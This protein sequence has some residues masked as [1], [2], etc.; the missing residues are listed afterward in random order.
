[1]LAPKG[2]N[3]LL[4]LRRLSDGFEHENHKD[5]ARYITPER[6]SDPAT[7]AMPTSDNV[8]RRAPTR[9]R[10]QGVLL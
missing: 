10:R 5:E 6:L 1:V 3:G 9:D 8:R 2:R 4:R 7:W